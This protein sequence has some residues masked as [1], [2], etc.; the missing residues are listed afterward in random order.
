MSNSPYYAST[1]IAAGQIFFIY[2][3]CIALSV[4]VSLIWYK[5][6]TILPQ[7]CRLILASIICFVAID[8]LFCTNPMTYLRQLD[9]LKMCRYQIFFAAFLFYSQKMRFYTFKRNI[10]MKKTSFFYPFFCI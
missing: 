5:L 2:S 6:K 3:T 10:F 1:L 9:S 7:W 8:E 4:N